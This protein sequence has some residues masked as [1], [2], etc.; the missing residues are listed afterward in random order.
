[1]IIAGW[2]NRVSYRMIETYRSVIK[3]AIRLGYDRLC[4][5]SDQNMKQLLRPIDL[6]QQHI[7]YFRNIVA[8]IHELEQKG[9]TPKDKQN[10]E[11][12][13]EIAQGVN[14]A[15][16]KVAQCAALYSKGYHCGIIP[17]DSGIKDMLGPCIGFKLPSG[18]IAHEIMRK[19]VEGIIL[20]QSEEYLQLANETG[21]DGL[22]VSNPPTW[23][24]HLVLVYFKRLHCNQR[25]P[26]TCPLRF[27]PITEELIGAMCSQSAPKKG[28]LLFQPL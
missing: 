13:M 22:A 2:G 9:I 15:S 24:V 11:L 4:A 16:Y 28:K 10:D 8:F 19:L 23:W 21:Y 12:V 17:I 27:H 5:Q 14:G 25:T 3:Q 18:P 20:D 7:Q 1:M 6:Y 26:Q